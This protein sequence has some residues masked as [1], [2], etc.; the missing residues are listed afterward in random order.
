MANLIKIKRSTTAGVTPSSL[1]DGEIAINQADKLLFFKDSLGVIRSQKI[2]FT[3]LCP[4]QQVF[5]SGITWVAGTAPSGATTHTYNWQQVGNLVTLQIALSYATVGAT[6][7]SCTLAFPSDCPTPI[8][9]S[10]LGD[11]ANEVFGAGY[12]KAVAAPGSYSA[13]AFT[14]H[15]R[16][17]G[18]NAGYE[19]Y[20]VGNSGSYKSL[21]LLVTYF[22]A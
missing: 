1:A 6:M 15:I 21:I 11:E 7:T 18:S 8:K 3:F 10:G 20:Y 9:P 19:I 16:Q 12:G 5:S 13:A 2:G 22:T 14:T 4:G 17:N